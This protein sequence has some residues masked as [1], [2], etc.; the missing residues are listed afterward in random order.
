M[1]KKSYEKSNIPFNATNE[2]INRLLVHSS[3]LAEGHLTKFDN[4]G[5]I[6]HQT[7][8]GNDFMGQL[9]NRYASLFAKNTENNLDN[10]D[11]NL[12]VIDKIIDVL[13][14]THKNLLKVGYDLGKSPKA[15]NINLNDFSYYY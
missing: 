5:K 11:F 15:I 10:V 7:F 6:S 14:Y 3:K 13:D 9:L 4:E 2:G 8:T 1:I 12:K